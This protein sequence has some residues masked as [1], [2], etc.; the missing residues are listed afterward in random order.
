MFSKRKKETSSYKQGLGTH[1]GTV[2]DVVILVPI[3]FKVARTW[4]M[5]LGHQPQLS[6]D[7]PID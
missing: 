6:D 4:H 3:P 7:F 1:S 2:D 5:K